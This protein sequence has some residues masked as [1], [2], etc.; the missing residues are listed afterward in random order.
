MG[1]VKTQLPRVKS[2]SIQGVGLRPVL[3]VSGDRVAQV[4]HVNADL[5]AAARTKL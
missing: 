2:E 1:V 4:C 5:V 3:R